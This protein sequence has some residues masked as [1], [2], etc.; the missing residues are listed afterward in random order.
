MRESCDACP[1]LRAAVVASRCILPCSKSLR[2]N[3]VVEL[4]FGAQESNAFDHL[5][6]GRVPFGTGKAEG[7]VHCPSGA[8]PR[9]GTH[10]T[11]NETASVSGFLPVLVGC[12]GAP[13]SSLWFFSQSLR[14]SVC[15]FLSPSVSYHWPRASR[16][17][18]RGTSGQSLRSH[19]RTGTGHRPKDRLFQVNPLRTSFLFTSSR[20][21][22]SFP[23]C[24]GCLVVITGH[25]PQA[26]VAQV[27]GHELLVDRGG[28]RLESLEE[29]QRNREEKETGEENNN[30]TTHR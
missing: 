9:T 24:E 17:P 5:F 30:H 28:G 10:N 18:E 19:P 26:E 23:S 8:K 3:V 2:T 6:G 11:E 7:S 21:P 27:F 22:W 16:F 25:G 12:A 1:L 14:V 15:F 13:G 4:P 20:V 29:E